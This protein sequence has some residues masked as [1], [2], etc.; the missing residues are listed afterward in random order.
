MTMAPHKSFYDAVFS[1]KSV[2]KTARATELNGPF[3]FE[4]RRSFAH[5]GSE[6]FNIKLLKPIMTQREHSEKLIS[7]PVFSPGDEFSIKKSVPQKERGWVGE[8]ERDTRQTTAAPTLSEVNE[9]ETEA[10][11]CISISSV[12]RK[13]RRLMSAKL[14]QFIPSYTQILSRNK[15]LPIIKKKNTNKFLTNV[16]NDAYHLFSR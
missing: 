7:I 3:T 16:P 12:N 9:A 13:S 8:R 14:W 1:A 4:T 2:P 11:Q 10:G 5:S 6:M 15:F